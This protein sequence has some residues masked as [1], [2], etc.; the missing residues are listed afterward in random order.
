MT[1]GLPAKGNCIYDPVWLLHKKEMCKLEHR[2][3]VL[4]QLVVDFR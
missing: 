4:M 2:Q 1:K 3:L